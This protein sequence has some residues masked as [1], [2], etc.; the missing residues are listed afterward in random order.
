M[1]VLLVDDEAS[2]RRRLTRLLSTVPDVEIAGE[3]RDGLEALTLLESIK[4]DLLFL[5]IQ[6]P[7]L[8]GFGVIRALASSSEMPLVIFAT[9]YDEHAMAAFE[10]NAIAYLLKPIELERLTIAMDRARRLLGSSEERAQDEDRIHALAVSAKRLQRIVCRKGSHFLLLDPADILWFHI[11]D[12][13]IVRAKT[14]AENYWVNYQMSHLEAGLDPELFFRARREVL[15]NLSRIKSVKPY[16]RS[17]FL[18]TMTDPG[19]TELVVS[20]RQAKE[21]RRRL[22]GL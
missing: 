3:A 17:T 1:R 15:V 10:A 2:A 9:S 16:D 22:P 20:E 8:D 18:L 21:L 19:E 12:G 4:P 14:S 6:M 5:D 13:G 11:E 7:E